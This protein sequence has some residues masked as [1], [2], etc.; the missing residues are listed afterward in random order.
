MKNSEII[1]QIIYRLINELEDFEKDNASKEKTFF[2]LSELSNN[3]KLEY[4]TNICIELMLFAKGSET[5]MLA[6][7]SKDDL[8]KYFEREIDKPRK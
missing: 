3:L 4:L 1:E 8:I 5:A 6:Y 7:K 2:F